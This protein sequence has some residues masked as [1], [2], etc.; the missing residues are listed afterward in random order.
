MIPELNGDGRGPSSVS[1]RGR[2]L[3]TVL[4]RQLQ[5]FADEVSVQLQ[6]QILLSLDRRLV[7]A[8]SEIKSIILCIGKLRVICR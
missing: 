8:N 1:S 3:L 6:V 7:D 2:V 5:K 4:R